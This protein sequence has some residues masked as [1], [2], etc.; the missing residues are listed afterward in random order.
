MEI[1]VDKYE[2]KDLV[3]IAQEEDNITDNTARAGRESKEVGSNAF[4][5]YR[6]RAPSYKNHVLHIPRIRMAALLMDKCLSPWQI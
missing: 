3:G 2:N 6:L 1:N 5:T 4:I